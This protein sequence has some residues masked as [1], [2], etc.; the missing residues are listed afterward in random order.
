MHTPMKVSLLG[1]GKTGSLTADLLKEKSYPTTIFDSSHPPSLKKL[2]ATDIVIAFVPGESFNR[3]LPILLEAHLPLICG[4][5]GVDWPPDLN[6]RLSEQQ[7]PWIRGSNFSRGML[8]IRR[9]L[10]LLCQVPQIFFG[11]Y[12]RNRGNPPSRKKGCSLGNGTEMVRMVESFPRCQIHP[13][14][15]CGGQASSDFE[16]LQR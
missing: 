14:R 2:Q 5:T 6:E 4:S 13:P 1:K 16:I 10:S 9:M 15:R 7:I 3:L 11:P 12:R 8:L